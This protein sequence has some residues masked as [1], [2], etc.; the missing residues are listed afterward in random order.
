MIVI[1]IIDSYCPS[2]VEA[3]RY[4]DVLLSVVQ[5]EKQQQQSNNNKNSDNKTK[6]PNKQNK[7]TKNQPCWHFSQKLMI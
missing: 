6:Q 2:L 3:L 4:E 1:I 7:Q 5:A